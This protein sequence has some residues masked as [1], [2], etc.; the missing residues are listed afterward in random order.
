MMAPMAAS[1]ITAMASSLIQPLA[2]LLINAITGKGVRRAGKGQESG[3]LPL[4]AAPLVMK[5]MFG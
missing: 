4:L 5:A 3:F 2:F 1:L